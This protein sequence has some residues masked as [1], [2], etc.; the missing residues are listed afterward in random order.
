MIFSKI[1]PYNLAT[2]HVPGHSRPDE[3]IEMKVA[4]KLDTEILCLIGESCVGTPTHAKTY[5]PLL[6]R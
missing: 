5:C 6:H 2:R 3:N 4:R 1:I